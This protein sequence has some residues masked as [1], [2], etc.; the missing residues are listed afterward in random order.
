MVV[1]FIIVP[2][3]CELGIFFPFSLPFR[4]RTGWNRNTSATGKLF[5]F[6]LFFLVAFCGCQAR[7]LQHLCSYSEFF[8]LQHL[9]ARKLSFLCCGRFN[10]VFL[11]NI[12]AKIILNGFIPAN[13]KRL[14]IQ[15]Q[16]RWNFPKEMTEM[17]SLL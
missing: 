1:H 4:R 7:I 3:G 8:C 10:T 6:I 16:N 12:I 2:F 17:K 5:Y 13:L 14:G 9:F 15:T 11:S